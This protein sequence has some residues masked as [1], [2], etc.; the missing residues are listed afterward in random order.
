MCILLKG[1]TFVS[2]TMCASLPLLLKQNTIN[3]GPL[4]ISMVKLPTILTWIHPPKLHVLIGLYILLAYPFLWLTAPSSIYRANKATSVTDCTCIN[5]PLGLGI[6]GS[7]T[8]PLPSQG[9][10]ADSLPMSGSTVAGYL[11]MGFLLL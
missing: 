8:N 7:S 6:T 1:G 2:K 11:S 5:S 9:P 4:N 10:S 3:P